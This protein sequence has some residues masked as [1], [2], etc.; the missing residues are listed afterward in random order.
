MSRVFVDTNVLV[1]ADQARS[2]FHRPARAALRRLEQEGAELWLSRQVL[3]EYLVVVT[4]PGPSGEAPLS[5]DAAAEAVEAFA[6]VYRVAEDGPLAMEA[7]LRLMRE[8]AVDGRQVHDANI[9]A[10][11][12]AH[13]IERLLTFNTGDFQRYRGRIAVLKFEDP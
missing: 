13:G 1:Y 6:R 10:T 9:V 8:I 3:R 7:L 4:R 11:M 2:S 5:R 12:L